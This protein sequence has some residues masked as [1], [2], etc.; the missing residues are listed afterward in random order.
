M[1][2]FINPLDVE[3]DAEILA[4]LARATGISKEHID[5][6]ERTGT[7]TLATLIEISKKFA[8]LQRRLDAYEP[9]RE[10]LQEPT[11]VAPGQNPQMTETEQKVKKKRKRKQKR[12]ESEMY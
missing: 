3:A 7:T 5:E 10:N 9:S 8:L 12:R 2:D 6:I 4:D 1:K 11:E